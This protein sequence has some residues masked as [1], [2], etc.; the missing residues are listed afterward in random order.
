MGRGLAPLPGSTRVLCSAAECSCPVHHRISGW[1][2]GN[3]PV[4]W[5]RTQALVPLHIPPSKSLLPK[6]APATLPKRQSPYLKVALL[7]GQ[8]EGD[9]L[10]CVSGTSIGTM[11]QQEGDEVGSTMQGSN[12]QWGRA[13][14]VGHIH[15]KPTGRNPCQLLGNAEDRNRS[16]N[17]INI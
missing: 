14:L 13:V 10:V 17:I 4:L 16:R 12:M 6:Q 1:E 11:L 15:T 7:A 8:V 3:A 5:V 2:K 9:G